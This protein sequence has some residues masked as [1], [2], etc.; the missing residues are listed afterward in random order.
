LARAR[1]YDVRGA[2]AA[3]RSGAARAEA[4]GR[5][6]AREAHDNRERAGQIWRESR[7]LERDDPVDRYLRGR[8]LSLA[9]LRT[10]PRAMRYHP[11]LWAARG[12]Y[13]PAM[14]GL[15]TDIAGQPIAIHRTWLE[16]R[17]DGGVA[18]APIELVK[19]T[20]A[21][22]AGG[23]IK[24]WRG[25]SGKSWADMPESETVMVA[26]GIEDLLSAIICAEIVLGSSGRGGRPHA[27]GGRVLRGVVA[28][29]LSLMMA[30]QLPSRV[31]RVVILAQRDAEPQARALLRQVVERFRREGREVLLVPPPGWAGFKDLN[32]L[33]CRLRPGVQRG[34]R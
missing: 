1:R 29:S 23:S 10:A 21:P 15:V 33:A 7:A 6:G 31:S 26:E 19:R 5:A 9:E 12:I 4:A 22:C 3:P 24:L 32:D 25:S 18:K 11:R 27:V 8:G 2:R 20:L 17:A 28:I 16:V 14:V 34:V 30:M 13:Y